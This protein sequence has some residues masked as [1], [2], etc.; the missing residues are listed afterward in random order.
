[1]LEQ[2]RSLS[3]ICLEDDFATAQSMMKRNRGFV[4]NGMAGSQYR[5]GTKPV[6][7]GFPTTIGPLAMD[8]ASQIW[9]LISIGS[10]KR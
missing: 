4:V 9:I 5:E 2:V 7:G 3:T 8:K 6:W 1:M 10:C